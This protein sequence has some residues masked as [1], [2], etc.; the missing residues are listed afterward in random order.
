MTAKSKSVLFLQDFFTTGIGT[1]ELD[2]KQSYTVNDVTKHDGITSL[3]FH[4]L[5]DTN[6]PQD[7]QFNV[8]HL[9]FFSYNTK[10]LI[11]MT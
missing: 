9:S 8:S 10:S 2:V 6:D 4:R 7:I 1:P 5:R 11:L 3:R